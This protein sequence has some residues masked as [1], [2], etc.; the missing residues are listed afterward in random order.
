MDF[1]GNVNVFHGRVAGGRAWLG[2]LDMP[3]P[4]YP[5]HESKAAT[6][7]VRPHEL[8]V[9]RLPR[10]TAS[11]RAEIVRISAASA[12]VKLELFAPDFGLP[13]NV[14]ITRERS[15]ALRLAG[16]DTVFVFPKR[17]RVFVHDYQI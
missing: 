7:Y 10:G 16:G 9:D 6:A 14:E 15:S 17:V 12:T 13:I 1:L 5:G 11:L 8:E 4:E 3:Y 2:G